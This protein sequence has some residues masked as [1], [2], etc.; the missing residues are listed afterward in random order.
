MSYCTIR[1]PIEGLIGKREVSPGNLVGKGEATLLDTVSSID[2]IR[3]DVSISDA[4][5][6]RF[7]AHRKKGQARGG[8]ALELM[9]ADGSVYPAQ[10]AR[11][12]SPT[13]PWT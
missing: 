12:S 1:S 3:V 10:G 11:S 8:A 5:Y 6:L 2:P 13:G 4:E 7:M 9:L